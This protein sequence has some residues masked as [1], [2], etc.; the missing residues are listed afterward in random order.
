[1]YW[2]ADKKKVPIRTI[3]THIALN[4]YEEI[5]RYCR[6]SNAEDDYF[7]SI[8]LS[9]ELRTCGNG[10]IGT[11]HPHF[12]SPELFKVLKTSYAKALE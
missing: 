9:Q 3:S 7:T 2:N 10:A 8:P 5:K 11:T 4:H 1:M 12:K 6:I